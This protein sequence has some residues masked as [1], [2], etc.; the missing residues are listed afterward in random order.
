MMKKA[1]VQLPTKENGHFAVCKV[2][3]VSLNGEIF[4]DA[5]DATPGNC[6][7]RVSKDLLRMASTKGIAWA[8][9][10]EFHKYRYDLPGG[11]WRFQ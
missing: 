9:S 6:N 1:G 3:V 8:L 2:L 5:G 10:K 11:V 7:S 4:T